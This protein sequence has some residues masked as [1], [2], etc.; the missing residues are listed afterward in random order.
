MKRR[1]GLIGPLILLALGFILLFNNLGLISWDIWS[2][3]W[4]FWPLILILLGLEILVSRTESGIAYA[5]VALL[6]VVVIVGA[7]GLAWIG[8]ES[9][10]SQGALT[11]EQVSQSL[12][13][14][15]EA[16]VEVDFGGGDLT[17]GAYSGDD[18]LM[19]GRLAGGDGG[20]AVQRYREEGGRAVLELSTPPQRRWRFF[21]FGQGSQSP[22]WE[23]DL[24][25]RVPLTLVVDA[26]AG[27]TY[28]DLRNLDVRELEF[29]AG[30][31][32][33]T[34]LFPRSGQTVA[35]VDGGVGAITLEIAETMPA[36]IR[37]DAGIGDLNIGRRFERR[38]EDVYETPGFSREE[39]YLDLEVDLGVGS[40]TVR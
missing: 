28:L 40:V 29:N 38:G 17:I 23:L 32:E 21:P 6:G 10:L 37:L 16:R 30:V 27:R 3:L 35:R 19:A 12:G 7:I 8:L 34:I 5:L 31:G 39:S 36:R 11:T 26:G 9:P 22:R 15:R 14:V 24:T 18:K 1:P 33:T 25:A 13:A 4:R 2:T 20:Q